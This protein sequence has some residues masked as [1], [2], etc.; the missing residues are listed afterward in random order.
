MGRAA[1]A[2]LT[3]AHDLA[4]EDRIGAWLALGRHAQAAAELVAMVE[5]R[6]LRE[7]RWGS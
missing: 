3:E 6:P 7:R 1:V 5:A 2:R 4:A